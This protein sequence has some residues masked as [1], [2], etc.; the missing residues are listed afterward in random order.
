M[1]II[2]QTPLV[3]TTQLAEVKTFYTRHFGFRAT[4]DIPEYLAL[5]SEDG[6]VELGF[7]PPEQGAPRFGGAGL[8]ICL[9]VASADAEHARLAPQGLRITRPLQDNPWGDRSFT[10]ED[11]VG[12]SLYVHHPIAPAGKYAGM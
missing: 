10:V 5:V 1:K 4:L 2:K 11:P 7:M 8:T 6:S 3:S 9:Q 12:I